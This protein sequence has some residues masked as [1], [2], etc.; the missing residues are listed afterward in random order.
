M[1]SAEE[2]IKIIQNCVDFARQFIYLPPSLAIGFDTCPSPRFQTEHNASE[3]EQGGGKSILWFNEVWFDKRTDEHV[4]DIEFFVF[5]ELR[6]MHQSISVFRMEN[7]EETQESYEEISIWQ[8]EFAHYIRNMD[9]ASE[10]KNV[11]QKVEMDANAY[12]LSLLNLYHLND[13]TGLYPSIPVQTEN[14][15]NQ[16]SRR[17]YES[18]PE[19]KRFLDAEKRCQTETHKQSTYVRS[20]PKIGANDPCPCGSG[21]KFKKCCRNKGIYD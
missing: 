21:R 18:K 5:H 15:V 17:Y 16:L 4:D 11:R 7:K 6:H 8:Y 10:E 9:A 3:F 19:L 14:D 1:I 20:T 12:A 13:D 2:K